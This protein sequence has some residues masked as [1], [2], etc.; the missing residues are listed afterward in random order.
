VEVVSSSSHK[1]ESNAQPGEANAAAPKG[2]GK[3][4]GRRKGNGH[5]HGHGHGRGKGRPQR[6]GPKPDKTGLALW[7]EVT[8]LA[9]CA[10]LWY[11][12]LNLAIDFPSIIGR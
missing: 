8:S 2:K 9:A 7:A 10:A 11:M 6:G 5:G 4:K 12:T 1:G 3:G